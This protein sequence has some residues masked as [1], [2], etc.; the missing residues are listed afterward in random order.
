VWGD[1]KGRHLARQTCTDLDRLNAAIHNAV[2]GPGG[3]CTPAI[4][5]VSRSTNSRY[6]PRPC[7]KAIFKSLCGS[8]RK[9]GR[10]PSG[11]VVLLERAQMA[12][13]A[14]ISGCTPR[15]AII[16]FKL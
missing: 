5:P 2:G 6:P 16:R 7:E 15:M 11:L 10:F 8:A 14:W 4:S 12:L 9:R 1:L 13:I 3:R